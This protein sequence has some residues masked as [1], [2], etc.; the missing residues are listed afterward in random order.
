M[1]NMQHK[2]ILLVLAIL[3]ISLYGFLYNSPK[4][5]ASINLENAPDYEINRA[6]PYISINKKGLKEAKTLVNIN[7]HYKPSWVKEFVAVE[8]SAT[9]NGQVKQVI[10]K[11]DQLNSAQKKLMNTADVGSEITVTVKY[12]P[13]NTLKNNDVKKFNFGFTVQPESDAKYI[14]GKKALSRYLE[15]SAIAKVPNGTFKNY[16]L[17]MIKFDVNEKGKVINA[18]LFNSCSS[19]K[20]DELLL[21]TI[22]QMP[23]WKPAEYANGQKVKQEFVLAVGNMANCMMHTF[24]FEKRSHR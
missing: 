5:E 4:E 10:S 18:K 9:Q 3:T 1:K 20:I 11:S 2:S 13:D 12:I 6:L 21:E 22:R 16:D 24:N 14:G 7:R 15:K 19:P 17:A 23:D 8:I